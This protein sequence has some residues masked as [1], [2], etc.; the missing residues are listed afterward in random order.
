MD[1]TIGQSGLYAPL[2]NNELP[3]LYAYYGVLTKLVTII[4]ILEILLIFVQGVLSK[5]F[6][7]QV[8]EPHTRI[9]NKTFTAFLTTVKLLLLILSHI[10][11]VI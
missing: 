6:Y 3:D 4:R 8:S 10:I 2:K 7:S 1:G 11:I 9:F 5:L